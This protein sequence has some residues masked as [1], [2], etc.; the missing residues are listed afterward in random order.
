MI[1][2][3]KRYCRILEVVQTE[4]NEE[5]TQEKVVILDITGSTDNKTEK[6]RQGTHSVKISTNGLTHIKTEKA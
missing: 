2:A 3:E 6:Q 1:K 4:W 5:S